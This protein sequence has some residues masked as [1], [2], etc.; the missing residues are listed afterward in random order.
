[1]LDVRA[2]ESSWPEWSLHGGLRHS[3]RHGAGADD[4]SPAATTPAI[5]THANFIAVSA[6]VLLALVRFL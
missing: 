1:M 6:L 3:A 4:A 5:A 2:F